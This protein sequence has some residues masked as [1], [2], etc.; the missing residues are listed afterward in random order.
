MDSYPEGIP[1][2]QTCTARK[3]AVEFFEKEERLYSFSLNIK[4]N[5]S[6]LRTA[7]MPKFDYPPKEAST[8]FTINS[9]VAYNGLGQVEPATAASTNIAG[10]IK[11]A[12]ASTDSDYAVETPV[13]IDLNFSPDSEFEIDAN[14]T[15][16]AAMVG[17]PR[18]LA[19]ATQLDVTGGVTV[20]QFII[21]GLGSTTTKAR[22]R[23][24]IGIGFA[25]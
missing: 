2:K 25:S 1:Q 12:V 7:G 9:V 21:V 14:S 5:M 24:N 17:T 3:T 13:A 4:K 15:V 16:T 18:D 19:S 10:I 11:R 23:P 22:V 6:I 8:A 20:R